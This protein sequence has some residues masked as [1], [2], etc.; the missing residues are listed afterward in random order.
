M[1]LILIA[2]AGGAFLGVM[3]LIRW[4]TGRDTRSDPNDASLPFIR[5]DTVPDCDGD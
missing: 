5:P 2:L 1:D 4:L 3:L